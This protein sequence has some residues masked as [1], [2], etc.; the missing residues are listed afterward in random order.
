MTTVAFSAVMRM[1]STVQDDRRLTCSLQSVGRMR[2][3]RVSRWDMEGGVVRRV[4]LPEFLAV[5]RT[6]PG[7][8]DF[9]SCHLAR[10]LGTRGDTAFSGHQ[11]EA[12]RIDCDM[13]AG[14]MISMAWVVLEYCSC[15]PPVSARQPWDHR[16][17]S[18]ETRFAKG[19]QDCRAVNFRREKGQKPTLW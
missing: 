16:M 2:V 3:I 19:S 5:P 13:T 8:P 11:N 7:N 10:R 9:A 14:L 12:V 18:R 17:K 15:A 1:L 4:T 6:S